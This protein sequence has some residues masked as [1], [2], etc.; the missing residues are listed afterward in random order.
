MQFLH[1][2]AIRQAEPF[3]LDAVINLWQQTPG[4]VLRAE[5]A[6]DRLQPLLINDR[7]RLYV[8]EHDTQVAGALLVGQD[9]RRGY[10]YH[11]A[12][13]EPLRDQGFGR[14]L[15][16]T[17]LEDMAAQGIARCQVS[18]EVDN[19]DAR[20]FWTHLGWKE[21][22]ELALFSFIAADVNAHAD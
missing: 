21:R 9:G 7:L 13:A 22:T 16:E 12:V 5:D 3:E 18:V 1:H 10:L 14:A 17:A 2:D 8:V 11:L 4:I 6:A 15:I 20:H 19:A